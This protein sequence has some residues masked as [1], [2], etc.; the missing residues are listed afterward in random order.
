[1]AGVRRYEDLQVWQLAAGLRDKVFALTEDGA[2]S[3]NFRFRDQI[4]DSS[5]SAPANIAEG[6]GRFRPREFAFFVRIARA[7]LLETRNHI[8]DAQNKRY[9]S[10][11]DAADLLKL[12]VRAT[13]AA[14]R[15]LKYLESCVRNG[16]TKPEL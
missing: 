5:S 2:V 14:T 12:Q 4:R 11:T 3:R 7:S 13:I 6:F 15:L 9:F 1:M 10:E 16:P 8:Q